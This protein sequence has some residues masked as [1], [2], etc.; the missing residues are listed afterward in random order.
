MFRPE[1]I[2]PWV[3]AF[4]SVT[5]VFTLCGCASP[6]S[7]TPARGTEPSRPAAAVRDPGATTTV[8]TA[9]APGPNTGGNTSPARPAGPDRDL[10]L[11]QG[12]WQDSAPGD[13]PQDVASGEPVRTVKEVSGNR[14]TL[15]TYAADGAVV[16]AHAVEFR[17]EFEGRV[18][19]FTFFNREVT[20]GPSKGQKFPEPASYMYRV[21]GNT[22]DE[23]WGFLPEHRDRDVLVK[24]WTRVKDLE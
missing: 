18:P 6:S 20:A 2:R 5:L 9:A 4:A 16:Y 11:L 23:C 7:E 24:R 22:W 21:K 15:T 1:T 17:L 13:V 3:V 14:E 12:R 8:T 19:V 10:R